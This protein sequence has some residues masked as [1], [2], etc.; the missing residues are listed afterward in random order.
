MGRK[1]NK[2]IKELLSIILKGEMVWLPRQDDFRTLDWIRI[3]EDLESFKMRMP[4]F[5]RCENLSGRN[6]N[7]IIYNHR[8]I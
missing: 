5:G 8:L 4:I 3:K 6:F 7:L 1:V 2:K